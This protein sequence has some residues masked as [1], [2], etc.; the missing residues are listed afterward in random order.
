MTG[1]RVYTVAGPQAHT[2]LVYIFNIRPS[3]SDGGLAQHRGVGED[4]A[5]GDICV[6]EAYLCR[7]LP[8]LSWMTSATR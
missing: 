5:E 2:P 6:D 8:T 4:Q 7:L 3:P 1:L